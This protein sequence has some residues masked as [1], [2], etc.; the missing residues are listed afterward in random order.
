VGFPETSQE[1]KVG[2]GRVVA[3]AGHES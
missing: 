1:R 3:V 2:V